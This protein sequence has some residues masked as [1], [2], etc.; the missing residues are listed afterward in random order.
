MEKP[1]AGKNILVVE[2]ETVFRSVIA[3]FLSSLGATIHQAENGLVAP[4][5]AKNSGS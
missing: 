4:G 2:D 1:L 3:G 5:T